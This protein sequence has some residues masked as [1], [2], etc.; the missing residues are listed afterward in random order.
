M[1]SAV[2]K[3]LCIL[4]M[5]VFLWQ[6][7]DKK[8]ERPCSSNSDCEK[9][10][11][12]IRQTC[13]PLPPVENE[14][15]V[16]VAKI[17]GDKIQFRLNEKVVLLGT[18]SS[19]PEGGKLSF[20]WKFLEQPSG[21]KAKI[22]KADTEKASFQGDVS[23][24]YIVEL[25]VTDDKAEK[26]APSRVKVEILGKDENGDP[27][28]NAGNDQVIKVGS[29]VKLNGANSSD[30]EGDELTF[31]WALKSKPTGSKAALSDATQK[32]PTFVADLPGRYIIELKVNDGLE[33]SIPDTVTIEALSDWSAPKLTS[34]VPSE[35]FVDTQVKVKLVGES[36]SPNSTVIFDDLAV[37]DK[38]VKYIDPKAIEV[39]LPLNGKTPGKYKIKVKK[40]NGTESKALEFTAKPLPLPTITGVTPDPV[41]EGTQV[42]ITVKGTGFVQSSVVLFQ[43]VPLPT[44]YVSGTELTAKLDLKNTLPGKYNVQVK[45]PGGRT[46][47]PYVFTVIKPGPPPVLRVLNPPYGLTGTKVTFSIHGQRFAPNAVILFNGKPIPSKRIRSD[48]IDA[49]PTLDLTNVKP[50]KYPVVAKN[51]DGRTSNTETFTVTEPNPTPK[52]SRIL[53]FTVFLGGPNKIGVYGENFVKGAKLHLGKMVLSGADVSFRSRT[54]IEVSVDTTKG[55]WTPGDVQ[56]V[57]ENPTGK[58]SNGFKVTISHRVPLITNI[59]P[60]GWVSKCDA[61]ISIHGS[62]FLKNSKVLFGNLTYTTTSTT[63]KLTYVSDKLLKFRLK[64]S[65]FSSGSHNV[66]VDNG[67]S[68]KSAATSFYIQSGTNI[69]VPE[70]RD[71]QPSSAPADSQANVVLTYN[72]RGYFWNGAIVYFDGKPQQTSCN[73]TRTCYN[74]GAQLDLTGY[75]PG[76]YKLAVHNPCSVKSKTTSDF[77]VT[78]AVKPYISKLNPSYAHPGDK[79]IITVT[80]LNFS[81]RVKLLWGTKNIPIVYRSDKEISTKDPIDFTGAKAGSVDVKVDNGNSNFSDVV[82]FSILPAKHTPRIDALSTTEFERGKAHSNVT[83]SGAGFTQKTEFF[84]NG[85]KVAVKYFVSSQV[86]INS[87]DFTSLKAGVYYV[88]AKEGTKESNRYPVLAKPFPPPKITRLNPGSFIIGSSSYLYIYGTKFCTNLRNKYYCVTNPKVLIIDKNGKDYGSQYKITR[89]WVSTA[90]NSYVYGTL[91]ASSIPAGSYKVYFQLPTGEKSNPALLNVKPPPPPTIQRFSPTSTRAGTTFTLYVYA[92]YFCPTTGSS[93]SKNPSVSIVGSGGLTNYSA[94]YSITR[95]YLTSTYGYLY[96]SFNAKNMKPGTYKFQITHPTTGRKSAIANFVLLP[97]PASWGEECD[98]TRICASG[99][100][101]A[102]V[103]SKSYCFQRCTT[104]STCSSNPKRKTCVGSGTSKFCMQ[105][106]VPEKGKCGLAGKVQAQCAQKLWCDKGVC[107]KAT[108]V[109]VYEKCGETGKICDS[110]HTCLRLSG[111]VEHGYCFPKCGSGTTC[112]GNCVKLTG[113]D[114]ACVPYGSKGDDEEC[115]SQSGAKFDATKVCKKGLECVNF[116]RPIC[117]QF[118]PGNCRTSGKTCASGRQCLDLQSGTSSFGGCFSKCLLGGCSKSHLQCNTA[119]NNTCWPKPPAGTAKYGEKCRSSSSN[120]TELCVSGLIC[121]TVQTGATF[122]FCSKRCSSNSDCLTAKNASGKTVSST[123]VASAKLCAFSCSSA[124]DCP[125]GLKCLGSLCGP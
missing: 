114:T 88:Y 109:K 25:V 79:K 111:S 73:S 83:V 74:L 78:A 86:T 80:G 112:N 10:E 43:A 84:F 6:C 18:K 67:P 97:P 38:R 105:A 7:S 12:C 45:S 87:L 95:T 34:L 110:K 50:G 15:P 71:V 42:T 77:L 49:L 24:T 51:P 76:I 101:C 90:T 121:V 116:A 66:Y 46:S 22:D 92:L 75:K 119:S 54:F 62:N 9:K 39:T 58:K 117:M 64:A 17:E 26:S 123:C 104:D 41:A 82:K 63:Y 68:A 36:F 61:D 122:G 125:K 94:N 23:G 33:D 108:E 47:A 3:F 40:R 72:S 30:P 29:T 53:P 52:I 13:R 44:T 113:G 60:S 100:V 89:T 8:V 1:R 118:W 85:K 56:A 57:V 11:R 124:N 16:A 59:T 5:S 20:L 2:W 4:M 96:G 91:N 93:C 65:G 55:T 28:A 31:A 107:K 21:S 106:N 14:R 81:K 37:D 69:P 103:D 32:E 102:T 35:G 48:E 120:K 19:D 98:S 115:G 70:I 99:L 27:I